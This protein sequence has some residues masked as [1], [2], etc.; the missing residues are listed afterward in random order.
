[1]MSPRA[2]KQTEVQHVLANQVIVLI[3]DSVIR[4]IYK[5]IILHLQ[6]SE[7]VLDANEI[8]TKVSKVKIK[9]KPL[10]NISRSMR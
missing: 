5:D 9:W 4:S 6:N 2:L 10:S 7:D 3:G 8:G 1:M